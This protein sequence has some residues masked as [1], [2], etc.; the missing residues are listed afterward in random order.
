MA[1]CAA[2][3]EEDSPPA[4]GP[5]E[6][7]DDGTISRFEDIFSDSGSPSGEDDSSF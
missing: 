3:V 1:G 6:S 7:C 5:S 2:P 4:C